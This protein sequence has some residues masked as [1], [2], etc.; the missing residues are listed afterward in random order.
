MFALFERFLTPTAAP[1]NPEPPPGL[2]AFLWS[3]LTL[4]F[5]LHW[6]TVADGVFGKFGLPEKFQLV[7]PVRERE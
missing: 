7:L 4:N 6:F 2:V 3:E 5:N 1:Q